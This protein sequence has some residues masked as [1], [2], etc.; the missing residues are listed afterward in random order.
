MEIEMGCLV[1]G[2]GVVESLSSKKTEIKRV[3]EIGNPLTGIHR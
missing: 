2:S 1:R 3:L